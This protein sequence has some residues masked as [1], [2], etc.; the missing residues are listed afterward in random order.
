[1]SF[2]NYISKKNRQLK[3]SKQFWQI[4]Q[5]FRCPQKE[6]NQIKKKKNFPDASC[7][8]AKNIVEAL[9][10]SVESRNVESQ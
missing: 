9:H 8:C 1:M 7:G 5:F 10:L 4:N 3:R 2:L 6:I